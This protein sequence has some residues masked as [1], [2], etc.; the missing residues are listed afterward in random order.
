MGWAR[1]RCKTLKRFIHISSDAVL[2]VPGLVNRLPETNIDV[3]AAAALPEMSLYAL[4][5]V[6]GESA[7][8]RWRKL[9]DMDAVSVR[10]SDVYGRMDRD[11]GAR[12]RHNAPFWVC[13]QALLRESGSS[14]QRGIRVAGTSFDDFGWDY[15]DAPS[16]A[17]GLVAI[18]QSAH[19]PK[20]RMY[21]L[22]LGRCVSHR[23][24]LD[25]CAYSVQDAE[26]VEVG[27]LNTAVTGKV[28]V[29]SLAEDHWLRKAPMNTRDMQEEFGFQATPLDQA[30]K[31][32]MAWLRQH[33]H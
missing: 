6:A 23:E 18:L 32:Y 22:A 7:V 11:T 24:L 26:L 5:K 21:H 19:R 4:S 12:N 31:E 8:A 15:V 9:Y 14:Q 1:V 10:F 25:A 13:R 30:V 2:G 3:D 27:T 33:S 20:Q 16:V 17:R 28:D 29:M